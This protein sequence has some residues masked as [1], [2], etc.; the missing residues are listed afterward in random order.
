M[1]LNDNERQH[2]RAVLINKLKAAWCRLRWIG[3]LFLTAGIYIRLSGSELLRAQL[4]VAAWKL[5]VLTAGIVVADVSRRWLFPY[6]DLS[7]LIDRAFGNEPHPQAGYIFIGI[8]IYYGTV[9]YAFSS[10]L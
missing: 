10:G 9:I 2:K 5:F 3:A 1:N 6:I 8:A 4:G 7:E